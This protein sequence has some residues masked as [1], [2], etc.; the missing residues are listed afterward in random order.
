MPR[1]RDVDPL[2]ARLDALLRLNLEDMRTKDDNI[3]IGDQILLLQDSGMSR[4]EAAKVLG[5][6]TNQVPSYL[7]NATN[8]KLLAKLEKK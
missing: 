4:T 7:R 3:T 2:V 8:K 5:I 1:Q 6:Q